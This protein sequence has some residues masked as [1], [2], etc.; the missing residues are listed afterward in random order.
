MTSAIDA[1][2]SSLNASLMLSTVPE[3][4]LTPSLMIDVKS[5]KGSKPRW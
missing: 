2:T 1:Q 5:Q 4:P 3:S